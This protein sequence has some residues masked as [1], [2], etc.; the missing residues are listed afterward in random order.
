MGFSRQGLIEQL[1]FEGH[2]TED[3]TY[4]VDS[5]DV[6][7]YEQA[8]RVAQSYLDVM[9]FSRQGLVDQLVFEGFSSEEAAH[10]AD[11][12]GL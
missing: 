10:G 8:A 4:A 1:E 12:V 5:L 2:S 11:A 9:P 3:A 6:D 7:W